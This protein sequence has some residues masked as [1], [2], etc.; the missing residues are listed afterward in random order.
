[1]KL[2][3]ITVVSR[4]SPTSAGGTIHNF[5]RSSGSFAAN[6][7]PREFYCTMKNFNM[8]DILKAHPGIQRDVNHEKFDEME[9]QGAT[10]KLGAI[11][12]A[13][14]H[15]S[16][17]VTEP[18]DRGK[19][20]LIREF[21]PGAENIFGYAKED[22]VGKSVSLLHRQEEIDRFPEL[23]QMILSGESWSDMVQL[24]RK[25]GEMFPAHITVYPYEDPGSGRIFTLGVSI[26]ISELA[27]LHEKLLAT[28]KRYQS[29]LQEL[30]AGVWQIDRDARTM[31]VNTKMTEI[32][33]YDEKEMLGKQI[34]AFMDQEERQ[35][36][37]GYLE[38]IKNFERKEY[39][40]TLTRKDGRKVRL[41]L[42]VTP[43]KGQDGQYAG[44]LA[45]VRDITR[46]KDAEEK[47]QR[48]NLIDSHSM[49]SAMLKNM[50]SILGT[51]S[52]ETEAHCRR[53]QDMALAIGRAIGLNDEE[54]G[55]LSLLAS[56]H[57]I[58]KASISEDLLLKPGKLTEREWEIMKK[59]AER[60]C[61][62][63]SATDEFAHIAQLVKHHH[64]HWDGS[65]YMGVK[66]EDIPLLSRIIAI[67]DA[68]DA[69]TQERPYNATPKTKEA[70]VEELQQCAG[71]QFDPELVEIFIDNIAA[72]TESS[73]ELQASFY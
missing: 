18:A 41:H 4:W 28:E 23:Q 30:N 54:L 56:L 15:I 35:T 73:S 14:R 53:L 21:S 66:G 52:T 40:H 70:A 61:K 5:K 58:G 63:L 43:L 48:S 13:C 51:K 47:L 2:S 49:R 19:D 42:S 38:S 69:M 65:G 32:M 31:M 64:E 36:A 10:Q 59:H 17:I 29:L 8:N 6:V 60:G 11:F 12:Q 26:D 55:E 46:E 7:K 50:L 45:G 24:R 34:F 68:Y 57:D 72:V 22:I 3:I 16:F 62:A 67:V 37:A 25:G 71:S 20:S 44:A 9:L 1:M 27:E 33:G 39:E